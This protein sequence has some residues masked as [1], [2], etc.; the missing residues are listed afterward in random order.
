MKLAERGEKKKLKCP[1]SVFKVKLQ[2][3]AGGLCPEM[4]PGYFIST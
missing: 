3:Q 4:G 2:T 1:G